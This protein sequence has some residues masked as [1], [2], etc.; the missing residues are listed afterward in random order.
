MILPSHGLNLPQLFAHSTTNRIRLCRWITLAQESLLGCRPANGS[1]SKRDSGMR[2]Q[3]LKQ[4]GY[5]ESS[6]RA[7]LSDVPIGEGNAMSSRE[8][9]LKH[10]CWT[11]TT[12]RRML[13]HLASRGAISIKIQ[14]HQATGWYYIFWR[15]TPDSTI[16]QTKDL[17]CAH[18]VI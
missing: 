1:V 9:W 15:N 12:V 13:K 14:A 10:D 2:L 11:Q 17:T 16:V 5:Q 7:L 4:E 8:I 18:V 6:L 3:D